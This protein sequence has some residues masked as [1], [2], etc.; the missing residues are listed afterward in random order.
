MAKQSIVKRI[1]AGTSP[2]TKVDEDVEIDQKEVPEIEEGTNEETADFRAEER[3][4]ISAILTCEEAVGKRKSAEHLALNTA[5][6]A[7]DAIAVLAGIEAPK[8]ELSLDSKMDAV[9]T[10][11]GSDIG[12][13]PEPKSQTLA[14]R[15]S[16]EITIEDTSL[17]G[18]MKTVKGEG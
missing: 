6:S 3:T 16:K 11:V 12:E 10:D 14:E 2:E 1:F 9:N 8:E 7:E 18:R 5:L 13:T 17:A 15:A 4:R